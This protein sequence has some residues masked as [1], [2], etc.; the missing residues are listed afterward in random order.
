MPGQSKIRWRESDAEKLAKK[1]KNF[2][3]KISRLEKNHPELKDIIPEKMSAKDLK[4]GIQSRK[5]Y[6]DIIKSLSDFTKRGAETRIE[7]AGGAA[8]TKWELDL[9]RKAT[10]RE[11]AARARENEAR[12][13]RPVVIGGKVYTDARRIAGQQAAKPLHVNFSQR[14]KKSWD[15]FK[16]YTE[17]LMFGG[18]QANEDRYFREC[19]NCWSGTFTQ[20][21]IAILSR[22]MQGVGIGK[23]LKAYYNGYDELRPDYCYDETLSGTPKHTVFLQILNAIHAAGNLPTLDPERFHNWQER[24]NYNRGVKLSQQGKYSTGG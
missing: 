9:V 15:N 11:N 6:N 23:C 8:T 3:A 16:R 14:S 5:Q 24:G 20:S 18:G 10:R 19:Q 13:S 21:E 7:G 1:V 22:D 4:K 2:N 17:K 12:Q